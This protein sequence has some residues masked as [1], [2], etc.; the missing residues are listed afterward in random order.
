MLRKVTTNN[1][2]LPREAVNVSELLM[3]FSFGAPCNNS[4]TNEK[5][6]TVLFKTYLCA[7]E[8]SDISIQWLSTLCLDRSL[9][10]C[11]G[12]NLCFFQ[13]RTNLN[14]WTHNCSCL[15]WITRY[16]LPN[17]K[18]SS[19][20]VFLSLRWKKLIQRIC[21]WNAVKPNQRKT[22]SAM[23]PHHLI[24]MAMKSRWW[25]DVNTSLWMRPC[26]R[27]L[28]NKPDICRPRTFDNNI[29][30][31]KVTKYWFQSTYFVSK[32]FTTWLPFAVLKDVASCSYFPFSMSI[33]IHIQQ[34]PKNAS[35]SSRL[36]SILINYMLLATAYIVAIIVAC[37]TSLR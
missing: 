24:T 17:W 37:A 35:P 31:T 2:Q 7:T 22:S 14:T 1:T 20:L 11:T 34:K 10:M 12:Q 25:L 36:F 13:V 28:C 8:M 26:C 19:V 21:L 18:N 30:T 29:H 9:K 23:T 6:S 16:F 3:N 15:F 32:W 33:I 27:V 5:H 4:R